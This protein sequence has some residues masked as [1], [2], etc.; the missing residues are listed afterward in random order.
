MQYGMPRL[1][2]A[3]LVHASTAGSLV[4]EDVLLLPVFHW[5]PSSNLWNV[6]LVARPDLRLHF[7]PCRRRRYEAT[8]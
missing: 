4:L 6:T 3:V 5:T 7:F 2:Q 8:R 1:S